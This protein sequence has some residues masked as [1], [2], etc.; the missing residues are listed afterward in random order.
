MDLRLSDHEDDATESNE[1]DAMWALNSAK[2][3]RF[4]IKDLF[5]FIAKKQ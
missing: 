4:K 3:L 5:V 2:Q 1:D